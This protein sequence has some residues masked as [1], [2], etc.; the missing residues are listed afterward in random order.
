MLISVMISVLSSA[1]ISRS[2]S[3]CIKIGAF[4]RVN[5]ILGDDMFITVGRRACE[6]ET[7]EVD[8]L[9]ILAYVF[10]VYNLKRIFHVFK[11]KVLVECK[12]F[13]NYSYLK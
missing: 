12:T 8:C 7:H 9:G 5:L 10:E 1:N 3:V 4:I 13:C 2:C 11:H 6:V